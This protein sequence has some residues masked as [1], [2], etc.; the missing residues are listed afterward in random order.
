M[1]F[2]GA[3]FAAGTLIFSS[4]FQA[5]AETKTILGVWYEGCEHLCE[6][7]KDA[8]A[9]S[10]FDVE[11][12]SVDIAQDKSLLPGVVETARKD[13]VDL[14]VTFGTSVTL[15]VIGTLDDVG[16]PRF[17]DD[18]PVVFTVVAD[19]FGTRIAESFERSGRENVAGTFNR[20]P[21]AVNVEIIRQY[22]PGFEKLGLLYHSNERNSLIKKEELQALLPELGIEFVALELDPGNPGVPDAALIP[23][24][25]AE[26]RERGV[27]WM[28]LGSSSFLRL[29]GDLYT[30]SAVE[31][32]IAIVSPYE[33]L[34]RENRALLSIAARYYDV[35]KLA[36][37]QALA[38]LRDGAVPGDLPILRA[39]NFAYVVNM[40]VARDLG[41]IP[42]FAFLQVAE[43]VSN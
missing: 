26:F 11:V 38:I 21:E 20:V 43:T 25:M 35:G 15:G 30:S 1:R 28:Y 39:S 14:V 16:N 4:A 18:I 42:P 10:G 40:D 34:V 9:V 8:I 37:D 36:A 2:I 23:V 6:G 7:L 41:R 5:D 3:C 32:G 17:L 22:D 13:Q 12:R 33:S 29:Y 24:R 27:R 31:N 19:P